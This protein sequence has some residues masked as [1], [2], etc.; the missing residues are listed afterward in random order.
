MV[1]IFIAQK[2][3]NSLIKYLQLI[4]GHKAGDDSLN[5]TGYPCLYL[6]ESNMPTLEERRTETDL[7]L[8]KRL[9]CRK[10][11]FDIS[12]DLSKYIEKLELYLLELEQRVV[13]LEC[14]IKG[15]HQHTIFP[16][17]NAPAL[18]EQ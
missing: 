10:E 9:I 4:I 15:A 1:D 18:K 2:Y 3:I 5:V 17:E 14:I 12:L 13:N 7:M 8:Q 16:A 11:D 6:K